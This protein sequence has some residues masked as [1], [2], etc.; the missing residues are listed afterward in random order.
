[1]KRTQLLISLFL[2]T[3]LYSGLAA[4]SDISPSFLLLNGSRLSFSELFGNL[5]I[6][7]ATASWCEPCEKQI[8]EIQLAQSEIGI[9]TNIFTISVSPLSDTIEIMQEIQNTTRALWTFAIDDEN[10]LLNEYGIEY[11]PT[12]LFFSEQGS[13][14]MKSEKFTSHEQIIKIT[15]N[16]TSSTD[17]SLN[18]QIHVIT[19]VIILKIRDFALKRKSNNENKVSI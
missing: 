13:L 9:S 3:T 6:I 17:Q 12:I 2:V 19:V 14:I 18:Y 1:M 16:L 5:T 4:S 7:D 8:N 15:K 11:L 10:F